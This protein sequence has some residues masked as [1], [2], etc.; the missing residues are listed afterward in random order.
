MKNEHEIRQEMLTNGTYRSFKLVSTDLGNIMLKPSYN[1]SSDSW[2]VVESGST[3]NLVDFSED[4]ETGMT[5][6]ITEK[7]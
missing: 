2:Q 3:Y 5:N 7:V 6:F 4:P 1:P